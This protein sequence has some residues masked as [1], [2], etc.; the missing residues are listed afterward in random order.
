MTHALGASRE[1][2]AESEEEDVPIKLD[3]SER[4]AQLVD[5]LMRSE[6]CVPEA[7][8]VGEVPMRLSDKEVERIFID[9]VPGVEAFLF[10][11]QCGNY[12]LKFLV[13]CYREGFRAFR[14]T[15]L[16]EHLL[17]L[18]RLVVHHG[19]VGGS[20]AA[21]HLQEVAEAFQECQAVQARAVERAG[22]RIKGVAA[23]FQGLLTRLAGEYKTVAVL[24]LAAQHVAERCLREDPVPT[25]YTNRLTADLGRELGL[26]ADDV[27]RAALDHLAAQRFAPLE[28]D[29]VPEAAARCRKL[30][31]A[32][33]MLGAFVAEVNSFNADSAPD[34]LSH[35]FLAWTSKRLVD[36]HVVLDEDTCTRVEVTSDFALAV[37]ED[38]FIG[39]PHAPA[40][41]RYRGQQLRALFFKL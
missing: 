9:H 17:W 4:V 11:G 20:D 10:R 27:R 6:V 31:D 33:A 26:N 39:M 34:S 29:Q 1:I 28:A 14:D 41:E 35:L 22:L 5:C 15:D 3:R 2:I 19:E 16:H 23:D 38:V 32:D 18:F 37:F 36:K 30:F 12:S 7:S 8:K 13:S 40:S 24:M 21:S 25:H